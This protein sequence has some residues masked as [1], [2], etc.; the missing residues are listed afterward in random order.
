MKDLH[1]KDLDILQIC[2]KMHVKIAMTHIF[3]ELK[4]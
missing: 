3:I 2:Y 1:S 4:L